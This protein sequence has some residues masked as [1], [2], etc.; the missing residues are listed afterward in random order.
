MIHFEY[1]LSL[2]NMIYL[3]VNLYNFTFNNVCP[4]QLVC[5]ILR[6]LTIGF[7]KSVW[8]GFTNH[9]ISF[10]CDK[11]IF[12]LNIQCQIMLLTLPVP[13]TYFSNFLTYWW[14]LPVLRGQ[15]TCWSVGKIPLFIWR[16]KRKVTKRQTNWV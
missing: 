8:T 5:K 15:Q 4:W 2:P 7:P 9:G 14:Y 16:H 3:T 12:T 10:L 11:H 1:I 13:I 6:N